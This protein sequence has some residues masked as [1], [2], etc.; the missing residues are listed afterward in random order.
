VAR[1]AT[2]N[3]P[4][5]VLRWLAA[6]TLICLLGCAVIE[7]LHGSRVVAGI[8]IALGGIGFVGLIA[9]AFY[10]VGRSEDRARER[11]RAARES[12]PNGPA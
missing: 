11:D 1:S 2:H 6:A 7:A 12:G 10:A 3:P 8:G 5:P 4:D 9:I